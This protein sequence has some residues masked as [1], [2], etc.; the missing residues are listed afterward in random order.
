LGWKTFIFLSNTRERFLDEITKISWLQILIILGIFSVFF[1]LTKKSKIKTPSRKISVIT[2][3]ILER[4]FALFAYF[5]PLVVIYSSYVVTLLP[6]YPYLNVIVPNFMLT[7]INIYIQYPM[8]INF[9]YFFGIVFICL[10]FKLPKPRFIR[11]HMVRGIMILAFQG[12]PD[13]IF[14]L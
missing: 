14:N 2:G 5:M 7:A 13:L 9:G 1:F 12:V 6:S 8:Y 4:C 11:F 3:N 10:Q